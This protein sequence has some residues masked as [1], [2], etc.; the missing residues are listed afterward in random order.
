MDRT[1]ILQVSTRVS[2]GRDTADN[3]VMIY[4]EPG[5]DGLIAQELDFDVSMNLW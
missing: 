5:G 2:C 1:S 4:E 3:D